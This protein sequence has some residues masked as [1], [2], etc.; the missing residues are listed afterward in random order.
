MGKALFLPSTEGILNIAEMIRI[1]VKIIIINGMNVNEPLMIIPDN[2]SNLVS[3][4]ERFI[5]VT[6]SQ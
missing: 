4:Q 1:Y 2:L 5:N 6:C 3:E